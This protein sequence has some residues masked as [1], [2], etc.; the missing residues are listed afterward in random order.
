M[1]YSNAI[2]KPAAKGTIS[3]S[4]ATNSAKAIVAATER[5]YERIVDRSVP[6]RRATL[7]FPQVVDEAFRQYDL[8]TDVEKEEREHKIQMAV[9]DIKKKF[10][11]NAILKGMNLEESATTRERNRQIGGHKSGT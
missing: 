11:K 7:T 6:I 10:G 8:F 3:L 2:N 5:L 4:S 9:L 1:G